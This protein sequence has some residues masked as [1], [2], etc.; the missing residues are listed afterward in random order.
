MSISNEEPRAVRAWC[1]ADYLWVALADGRQLA[2]PLAY[3]PRLLHATAEQ[4]SRMLMSG[5][6]TGLH[7]EEL[8]EDISVPNLLAASTMAKAS[9]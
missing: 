1:D 5:G 3:F 2:V 7:W 9:A 8:D 4:R 6:G